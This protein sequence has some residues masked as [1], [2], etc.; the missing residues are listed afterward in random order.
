MLRQQTEEKEE[1]SNDK[2]GRKDYTIEV[3]IFE[4]YFC[5]RCV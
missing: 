2:S 3:I 1:K 4:M 5:E